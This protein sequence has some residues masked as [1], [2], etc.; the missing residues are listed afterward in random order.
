MNSSYRNEPPQDK[1]TVMLSVIAPCLNEEANIDPLVDR[2]SATFDLMGVPAEI[3]LVDD[4]STDRT[5]AVIC[6]RTR[7]DRR[8]RG[9][10]HASNLGMVP[11]WQ[12]GLETS[13]GG[14]VCLIDAD[15]QNRPEDVA[16]LYKAYCGN[17]CD[18]VQAVRHPGKWSLRDRLLSR[19]LNHLLNF[20]FRMRSRD[21][22]SGFILCRRE[23]LTHMLQQRCRY[24][25]FQNLLGAAAHARGYTIYEVDTVFEPRHSGESFLR[26]YPLF[27][28]ARIIWE[29][30]K[31][32]IETVCLTDVATPAYHNMT[33]SQ[34]S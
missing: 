24:R 15:L 28:C 10:R 27:F 34:L 33:N 8:V 5:W 12:S 11:A 16:L 2:A 32:R 17:T 1:G 20:V 19:G 4:G 30:M 23:V 21:N 7:G 13:S 26:A 22:K 29:M 14:L 6:R 9:I 18:I 25:H 31:Y 3:V